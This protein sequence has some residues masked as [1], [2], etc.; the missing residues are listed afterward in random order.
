MFLTLQQQGSNDFKLQMDMKIQD[1]NMS[2]PR[3]NLLQV[4]LSAGMTR[5][6]DSNGVET[7]YSV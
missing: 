2:F 7:R 6:W 5:M 4:N 1:K 3:T